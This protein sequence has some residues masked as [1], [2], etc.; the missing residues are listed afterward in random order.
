MTREEILKNLTNKID[1]RTFTHIEHAFPL[2]KDCPT[3]QGRGKYTLNFN[4]YECDCEMQRLLQR[5]FFAANIGREYHNICLDD[6]FSGDRDKIVPVVQDYIE[7]FDDN[8]Y[9]GVGITFS[10]PVGTG[11]TFAM[12]C[13]LKELIK[14]GRKVYMVNFEQL[15][16][17]WASRYKDPEA[18]HI[19]DLAMGA[20]VLGVD[21]W[22]SDKRNEGGFLADG[23]DRI[24]RHRTSN[25]LPILGTTNMS[26]QLEEKEFNKAFSLLSGKNLR[27][28]TVG[29]D[30]RM[31]ELRKMRFAERDRGDR[32]PIC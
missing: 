8:F 30:V 17:S 1:D 4:V 2:A 9:Y 18:Q 16:D 19:L 28:E 3:C 12:T 21:E 5:H 10:G 25:L 11:K 6:F 31:K 13:V 27:V 24:A 26:R 14:Q 32:R 22:R 23:F 7:H 29:H 15:I 20:E